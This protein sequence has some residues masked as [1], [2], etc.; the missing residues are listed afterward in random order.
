MFC[1]VFTCF[2]NKF[3]SRIY[4]LNAVQ[5]SINK[6]K[7]RV[8]DLPS[9]PPVFFRKTQGLGFSFLASPSTFCYSPRAFGW[10]R[11]GC[12]ASACWTSWVWAA[13]GRSTGWWAHC[14]AVSGRGSP[15]SRA[16]SGEEEG[17]PGGS[18]GWWGG[19]RSPRPRSRSLYRCLHLP[20]LRCRRCHLRSDLCSPE[21]EAQRRETVK[22]EGNK[23]TD[24]RTLHMVCRCRRSG[25]GYLI[26]RN[27]CFGRQGL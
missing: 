19:F 18:A 17:A 26:K 11:G 12:P 13:L 8:D 2:D 22:F 14:A 21:R 16:P 7:V 25:N 6:K 4:F 15:W 9:C 20:L 24:F 10:R 5:F 3:N 27:C 23:K 1:S